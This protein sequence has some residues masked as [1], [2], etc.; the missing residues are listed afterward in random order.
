MIDNLRV[1]EPHPN[2]LAFY[3]GRVPG[4]RFG[5]GPNWVD[6]G[7]LSLGIASYAI[8]DDGAAVV[9]DTH[10]S[11][12]HAAFIRRT[13]E[14]RGVRRFTVVLSHWHLDHIAGNAVFADCEIIASARTAGH[15]ARHRAAI[16]TGTYDGPPAIA[17]LVM[18]T[19]TFEGR[20]A[21]RI[22]NVAIELLHFDIHSDDGV[23]LWL[24]GVRLLLAGDTLEDT[25]TYVAEPDNLA[26]HL[27]E[28]E[29]LALLGA[30]KI[31]PNHGCP[32]R[33][34]SG[35]YGPELTPATCRY[36]RTLLAMRADA[37]LRARPLRDLIAADL[38]AGTLVYLPEYEP[39]HAANVAAVTGAAAR[40]PEA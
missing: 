20:L 12:A 33:I 32:E 30:D 17:P 26:R 24:P 7:A 27:P 28:L 36:V 8:V 37:G 1:L 35:G 22:G 10:V 5:D 13:L 6:D 14:E 18:P 40:G 31:L 3:D 9:Y 2:V 16:E 4:Y 34:A 23:V 15:L 38:A 19:R 11:L 29:R 25:V 39:V 21:M